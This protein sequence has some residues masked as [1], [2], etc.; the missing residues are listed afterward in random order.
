MEDVTLFPEG[1]HLDFHLGEAGARRNF[2]E[3]GRQF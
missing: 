2:P 3:H 1:K